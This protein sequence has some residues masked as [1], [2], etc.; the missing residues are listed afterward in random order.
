MA[1]HLQ[2]GPIDSLLSRRI[3]H[4]AEIS[5]RRRLEARARRSHRN[6]STCERCDPT[7]SAFEYQCRIVRNSAEVSSRRP[8][9][10]GHVDAVMIVR[11]KSPGEISAQV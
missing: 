9:R 8:N 1:S 5:V 3:Y 10:F 2:D 11:T 6:M 4:G 7:F